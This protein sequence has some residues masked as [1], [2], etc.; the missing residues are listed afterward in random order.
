MKNYQ[1]KAIV[2]VSLL[3]AMMSS[4]EKENSKVILDP[5]VTTIDVSKITDTSAI[6]GGLIVDDGGGSISAKGI[7]WGTTTSPTID[8]NKTTEGTD[9][10]SFTSTIP[11]LQPNTTYYFRAYASNSKGTAYGTE[12]SFTTATKTLSIP[13]P[14]LGTA[15]DQESKSFKTV[16][17]GNQT[18][19]AENLNVIHYNDG[20]EI[21]NIKTDSVWNKL[22]TGAYCNY[23]ND[24]TAISNGNLYNWYAVNTGKICPTGWHV[25][26]SKEWLTLVNYLIKNGY[27]YN[28]ETTENNIAKSLASTSKWDS[29]SIAGCIG[30]NPSINNTSGFNA[31]PS[32]FRNSKGSLV[33][34]YASWWTATWFE[35]DN[36]LRANLSYNKSSFYDCEV[37]SY[38][39]RW[40]GL[41]VRCVKDK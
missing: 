8:V 9:T 19:M 17:I 31:L 1:N 13:T 37:C 18:W 25:P 41:S 7:C 16:V 22:T 12:K 28:S 4:C 34:N 24:S 26:D 15:I 5:N 39:Y 33:G 2:F 40:D 23:N 38:E 32:S 10:N 27:N 36:A 21:P 14:V 20:T 3:V 30:N 29:S 11:N 6:C 35:P